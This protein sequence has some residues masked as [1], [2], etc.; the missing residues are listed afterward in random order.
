MKGKTK[1]IEEPNETTKRQ[2]NE[3]EKEE[4]RGEKG[5]EKG[6]KRERR[7]QQTENH[8]QNNTYYEGTEQDHKNQNKEQHPTSNNERNVLTRQREEIE[9]LIEEWREKYAEADIAAEDGKEKDGHKQQ[10]QKRRRG[11]G[12]KRG[13]TDKGK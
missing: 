1:R 7:E 5:G 2:T 8:Q 13:K 9:K 11:T 10:T 4:E 6:E 3:E 12:G